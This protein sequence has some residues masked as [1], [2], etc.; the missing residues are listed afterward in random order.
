MPVRVLRD[1][2]DVRSRLAEFGVT[3]EEL[4]EIVRGVVAARADATA[5]D[6]ASAEGLFAYIFGTRYLRQVFRSHGWLSHSENNVEGVRHPDRQLKVIYQSVDRAGDAS[7][8]PQAVSGKGSGADRI[9]SANQGRLFAELEEVATISSAV[10]ELKFGVWFFCVSV[11][12]DDVRAELSMPTG[13][14]GGNFEGFSERIFILGHGDWAAAVA[15]LDDADDGVDIEPS[16][17]RR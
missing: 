3:L 1:V 13:V 17:S 2:E 16:V 8:T 7:H 15:P 12:G 4:V 9:I 14:E 10:D 5:D 6:P 11:E